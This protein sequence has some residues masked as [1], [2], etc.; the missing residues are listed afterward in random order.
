MK[1]YFLT[2]KRIV[3]DRRVLLTLAAV[4]TAL[5]I[6]PWTS[7]TST[8][9]VSRSP[10][11]TQHFSGVLSETMLVDFCYQVRNIP[12]VT[13]VTYRNFSAAKR[14]ATITV[15]YNPSETSVRQVRIFMQGSGVLWRKPKAT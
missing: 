7:R 15:Y 14:T 8:R 5:I 4:A 2:L 11:I 13:G 9:Y 1:R 10:F 3:S 12:G 6:S